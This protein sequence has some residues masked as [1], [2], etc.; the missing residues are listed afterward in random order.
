MTFVL[1][2]SY[3]VMSGTH[4]NGACC[5]DYGNSET[6]DTSDGAGQCNVL[7]P[8]CALGLCGEFAMDLQRKRV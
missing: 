4:Y 8:C 6:D 3:A 1:T 5:F 2:V 7:L